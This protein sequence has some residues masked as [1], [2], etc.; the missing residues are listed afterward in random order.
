MVTRLT[1]CQYIY[2]Y[3]ITTAMHRNTWA[4][5]ARQVALLCS[6][7]DRPLA[8][9]ASTLR[10]PMR[11]QVGTRTLVMPGSHAATVRALEVNG[12][13]AALARAGDA[14]EVR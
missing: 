6:V 5:H 12:V 1:C 11:A 14:V 7:A 3:Y 8:P 4:C 9:R 2:I 13:P 10:L